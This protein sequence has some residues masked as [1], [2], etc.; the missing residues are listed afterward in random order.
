MSDQEAVER[1]APVAFQATL[2]VD[3][4]DQVDS[5]SEP[6]L[7]WIGTTAQVF[8]VTHPV[9]EV[10]GV[11]MLPVAVGIAGTGGISGIVTHCGST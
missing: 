8:E 1:T 9:E 2:P 10:G 4:I 11:S 7:F 3:A 5:R 6:E